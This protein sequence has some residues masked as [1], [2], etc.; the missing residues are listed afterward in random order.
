MVPEAEG[1][2]GEVCVLSPPDCLSQ[3]RE[4]AGQPDLC[5]KSLEMGCGEV[6]L[7]GPVFPLLFSS[8]PSPL[9]WQG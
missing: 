9:P 3:G 4:L 1:V 7:Q 8:A 5:C 6:R 2:Q